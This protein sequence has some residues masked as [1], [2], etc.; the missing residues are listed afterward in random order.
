MSRIV[1]QR[2]GFFQYTFLSV[3]ITIVISFLLII[4]AIIFYPGGNLKGLDI[5]GYSLLYNGLCDIRES[6]ALN[7]EPNLLTSILLKIGIVFLSCGT[8]FF[9]I[10]LC[11]FFQGK[12]ST[13]YLSIIG[14]IFGIAQGPLMILII[15]LQQ[16]PFDVHM[17]IVIIA[18]LFQYIAVILY[19][20]AYF[21]DRNLPKI[22]WYS[23]LVVSIA[24]ITL[25]ALVGIANRV[26]GDFRFITN[27]LGTN[28]FNFLSIIIYIIQG[29]SLYLYLKSTNNEAIVKNQI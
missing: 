10:T 3:A 4:L 29:V 18:P 6:L 8:T 1:E 5:E 14:S 23:F 9:F 22:N 16:V 7:G 13:R 12:K 17:T 28:L 24:A 15:Y 26:G 20:I 2:K 27:R 11:F 25:S 21:I 19:T